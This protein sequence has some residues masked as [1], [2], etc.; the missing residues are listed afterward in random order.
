M[1]RNRGR[2]KT[3]V[4][5]S[6]K[7]SL[8]GD[9][10]PR[11]TEE[12]LANPSV[13]PPQTVPV[14]RVVARGSG[15]AESATP[16][17]TVPREAPVGVTRAE[18]EGLAWHGEVLK[19]L[20]SDPAFSA[21]GQGHSRRGGG[22]ARGSGSRGKGRAQQTRGDADE[23]RRSNVDVLGYAPVQRPVPASPHGAIGSDR[24]EF[25]GSDMQM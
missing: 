1:P 5:I 11:T 20:S 9:V 17:L 3:S 16:T 15:G 22:G 18:T 10:A 4:A 7:Q 2:D 24:S 14:P 13:A 21:H 6:L 19:R 23:Y 8:F 25:H 12:L